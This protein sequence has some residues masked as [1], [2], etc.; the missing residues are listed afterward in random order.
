[1]QTKTISR[2]ST[3]G[4]FCASLMFATAFFLPQGCAT[5]ALSKEASVVLLSLSVLIFYNLYF[6]KAVALLERYAAKSVSVAVLGTAVVY[7]ASF[8]VLYGLCR[9]STLLVNFMHSF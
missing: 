1:M 3:L 6:M 7:G 4:A 5:T 2:V 8:L 9:S